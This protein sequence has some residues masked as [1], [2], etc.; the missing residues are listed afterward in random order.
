[1][2][3]SIVYPFQL[4]TG[5]EPDLQFW[6]SISMIER[7]PQPKRTAILGC[8]PGDTARCSDFGIRHEFDTQLVTFLEG[9]RDM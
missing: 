4:P 1:V 5:Q 2:A 8:E 3:S 6:I 7:D 9:C